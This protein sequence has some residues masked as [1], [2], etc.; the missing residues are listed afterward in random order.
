[1]VTS[2][3]RIVRDDGSSRPA[4]TRRAAA[5]LAVLGMALSVLVLATPAP[6]AAV[7]PFAARGSVNQVY[8]HRADARGR[9]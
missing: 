8:G 7:A 6:A 3:P 2:R 5:V 9:R 4:R 1:M